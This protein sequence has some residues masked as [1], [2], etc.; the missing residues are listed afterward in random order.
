MGISP[1]TTHQVPM[2]AK[3]GLGLD[4][5]PPQP[6]AIKESTEAGEERPVRRSQRRVGHLP[7]EHH[8][9]MAEHDDLNRQFAV[10]RKAESEQLYESEERQIEERQGHSP[11]SSESSR[12]RK[13][14]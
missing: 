1:S 14:S 10:L 2:P 8:H 11:A 5:E 13:S 7:A 4:E 6:A 9:L 3:Q 12:Q